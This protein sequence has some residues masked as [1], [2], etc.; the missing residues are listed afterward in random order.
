L[1]KAKKLSHISD[2]RWSW[3]RLEQLMFRLFRAIALG[4]NIDT[5]E[6]KMTWEEVALAEVQR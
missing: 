2:Q 4:A 1:Y 3:P 6:F 5:N